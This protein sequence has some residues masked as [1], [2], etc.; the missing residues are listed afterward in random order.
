MNTLP[1]LC[2]P[3]SFEIKIDVFSKIIA[4]STIIIIVI[5]ID[6]PCAVVVQ[7]IREVIAV[8]C[9]LRCSN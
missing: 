5:I 4:L 6:G 1:R 9:D 7:E 2:I 3:G 8:S